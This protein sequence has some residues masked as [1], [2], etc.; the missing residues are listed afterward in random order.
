MADIAARYEVLGLSGDGTLNVWQSIMPNSPLILSSWELLRISGSRTTVTLVL[1]NPIPRRLTVAATLTFLGNS[2]T[3]SLAGPEYTMVLSVT[4][5]TS[6]P[7]SMTYWIPDRLLGPFV[8]TSSTSSSSP[9]EEDLRPSSPHTAPEGMKMR[10][11]HALAFSETED[12]KSSSTS[13]PTDIIIMSTPLET[14]FGR[15]VLAASWLAA[16]MT[17]S[18]W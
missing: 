5:S 18:Q 10:A 15:I 3:A 13:A 4:A 2:F 8:V 17:R 6:I 14:T 16:S 1:S 12:M 7:W 11:S 9:T